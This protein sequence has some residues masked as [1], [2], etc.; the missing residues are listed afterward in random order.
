MD[1]TALAKVK[2]KNMDKFFRELREDMVTL[3]IAG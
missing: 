2:T 3:G 1:S